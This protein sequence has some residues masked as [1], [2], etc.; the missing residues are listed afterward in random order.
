[1]LRDHDSLLLVD[2]QV[3]LSTFIRLDSQC[4]RSRLR[5]SMMAVSSGP[6]YLASRYSMTVIKI[7]ATRTLVPDIAREIMFTGSII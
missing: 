5:I 3:G 6:Q 1:M 7:H 2:S 4:G